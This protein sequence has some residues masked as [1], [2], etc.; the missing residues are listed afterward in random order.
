MVSEVCVKKND[1]NKIYRWKEWKGR[2]EKMK[3]LGMWNDSSRCHPA[4][5]A[6]YHFCFSRL[7][8]LSRLSSPLMTSIQDRSRQQDNTTGMQKKCKTNEV[9]NDRSWLIRS[10]M[11]QEEASKDH[12]QRS[13]EDTKTKKTNIYSSE[14]VLL[15]RWR[16]KLIKGQSREENSEEIGYRI[17]ECK[18]RNDFL[19]SRISSSVPSFCAFKYILLDDVF[20]S[21]PQGRDLKICVMSLLVDKEAHVLCVVLCILIRISSFR[22]KGQLLSSQQLDLSM[23]GDDFVRRYICLVF[24]SNF[25]QNSW[26]DLHSP[27]VDN[28]KH[29]SS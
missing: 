23:R 7:L 17:W 19:R 22:E 14:N 6:S 20:L 28:K 13:K 29:L 3:T 2:H 21:S 18:T 4:I 12:N 8:L 10:H 24:G 26:V 15:R 9:K 5:C 27:R 25:R 16:V 11:K 1:Q